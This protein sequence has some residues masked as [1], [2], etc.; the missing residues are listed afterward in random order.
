M[1]NFEP[2]I[3]IF[4]CIWCVPAGEKIPQMPGLKGHF[5][6]IIVKTACTG[7][8]DP[9]F[10]LHVFA[11]GADGVM[12]AGCPL[13]ECHYVSGNFKT[14]RNMILLR[15]TLSQFGI[16]PER[17]G[18]AW[19]SASDTAA[20]LTVLNSFVDNITRLGP[21]AL[22]ATPADLPSI[23]LRSGNEFVS[24]APKAAM[25]PS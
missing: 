14:R 20:F 2:K 24:S 5:H 12:V 25:R 4:R 15:N 10:V 6:P 11:H 13:G 22:F 21:L 7:R 19:F 16:E 18:M 9:T 1:N 3:V 8:I 17:L 23:K